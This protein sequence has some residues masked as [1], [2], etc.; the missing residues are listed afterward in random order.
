M[1]AILP[2]ASDRAIEHMQSS[3]APILVTGA[4]TGIGRAI[5]VDLARHGY[6]VFG[7]VRNQVDA[8]AL[9]AATPEGAS[10]IRPLQF[11][12]TDA[13]T[14]RHAADRLQEEIGDRGL[15]ALINNAGIAVAAPLE[16]IPIADLQLQ[17]D[18]NFTGVLRCTQAFL[19]LVKTARGRIIQISSIAGRLAFPLAGPYHASKHALEGLSDVLRLELKRYGIEVVVVQPGAISTPI[20]ETS[21]KR[22]AAMRDQLPEEAMQSY[23]KLIHQVG[24][25]T[26]QADKD[27]DDPQACA[28][29]VRLALESRRPRT[30]YIVGRQAKIGMFLRRILGDRAMDRIVG[31]GLDLDPAG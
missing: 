11:D 31:K 26:E 9:E 19:P 16:Y 28:D 27:G 12:V 22:A 5:A 7:S 29:V 30:R 25:A 10:T 21:R 13:E 20:W 23:G 2:T 18:I 6:L 17:M 1:P 4:S 14:I 24:K 8:D 15:G 3:S